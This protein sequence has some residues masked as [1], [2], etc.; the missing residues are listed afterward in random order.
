MPTAEHDNV[1]YVKMFR[2]FFHL[3]KAII[4]NS[5]E[6]KEL[7]EKL[8]NKAINCYKDIVGVGSEI[9]DSVNNENFRDKYNIKG[10]YYLYIGR[11][12][13]NK[14]AKELF[15]FYQRYLREG[16]QSSL[17]LIGRS[18][19]PI[20]ENDKIK[21]LGFLDNQ[22]KFDALSGAKALL[23]PS[24]YESLSI[25]TLEAWALGKVVVANGKTEVL[26]GQCKR[27]NAGLWYKNYDEFVKILFLL[28][29]DKELNIILGKNGKT[30]FNNNYSSDIIKEKYLKAFKSIES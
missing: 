8:S 26:V 12:D 9:P 15:D 25:V 27:S 11:I 16:G 13:E 17:V 7:L 5:V 19:L 20:P 21:H 18:I 4:F 24:Q 28:D 23:I 30:F 22:D 2:D 6:E 3:P 10:D 29:K 14:G 1:V